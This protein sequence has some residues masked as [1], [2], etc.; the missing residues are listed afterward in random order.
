VHG[1]APSAPATANYWDIA[2]S[3]VEA[4]YEHGLLSEEQWE[5]VEAVY[6]DIERE[7]GQ[8]YD[9]PEAY[10]VHMAGKAADSAAVTE[11]VVELELPGRYGWEYEE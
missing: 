9:L 8:V 4:V 2:Y 11:Q 7:N 1:V 3:N 5:F 10:E 6:D